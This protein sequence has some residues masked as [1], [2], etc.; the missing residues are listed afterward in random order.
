[1]IAEFSTI[2]KPLRIIVFHT[3]NS[4]FI[5]YSSKFVVSFFSYNQTRNIF[6]RTQTKSSNFQILQVLYDKNL[7]D[8]EKGFVQKCIWILFFPQ[9]ECGSDLELA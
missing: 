6:S 3:P 5:V 9:T 7:L 2:V 1:M 4:D 8:H